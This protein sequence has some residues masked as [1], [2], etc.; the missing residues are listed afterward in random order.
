MSAP[1][2]VLVIDD[3]ALMRK[4]IPQI[5]SRDQG[6]Q[7]VGT[8]MDGEF[9]LKK[10]EEL[11]PEVVT[12]DLEMPRMDGMATLR[13][14]TKRFRIPVIMVSAMTTE[15]ATSTFKALALG[16]LDF[17]AKPKDSAS[18][19]M[20]EIAAELVS[21]I[22]VA[23]RT[24]LGT[25]PAQSIELPRINKPLVK[26][27]IRATKLVTIGIS[28]G[29]PNALQYLLSQ[30]P[31]DFLGSIVVVQHM[32]EGF[33]DMFARRLNECC[34]IDVKEAQSGDLLLAGRALI[35]PGN[36]HVRVRRMA[37]GNMVVLSDEERVNGH[38]PSADIL[39]QSAAQE[40]GTEAIGLLMTGMGEDGAEGLGVM[41]RNGSLT[42]AQDEQ[43]CVVFGMPK[44]AIDRGY[45]QRVVS[46][47]LLANTLVAQCA[48]SKQKS[49]LSVM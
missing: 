4:L 46:L 43:S 9:G 33:T 18:A 35:C 22:K 2:R 8:A 47:D 44:I 6:I 31:G 14:I 24:K 15:G 21:K 32:P 25:V 11:K 41:R 39:F 40:F 30:L 34:A 12:L 1:I 23:A 48:P 3:S 42:I 13:Q 19:K 27:K 45:A 38:R 17:V 26:P 29:G 5:L 16:A 28:T 36:R 49:A 37:L 10:I 7:V 20:E